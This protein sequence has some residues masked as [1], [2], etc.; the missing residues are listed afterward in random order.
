MAE[1]V[2]VAVTFG[3]REHADTGVFNQRS[4]EIGDDLWESVAATVVSDACFRPGNTLSLNKT[5]LKV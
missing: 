2:S 1:S 4:R 3:K 5:C